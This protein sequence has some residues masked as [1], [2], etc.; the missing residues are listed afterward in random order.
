MNAP[1]GSP[2]VG[3]VVRN[4]DE[5]QYALPIIIRLEKDT[6]TYRQDAL[7]A[8]MTAVALL[9]LARAS[10]Q[11]WD[12]VITLWMND[13]KHRKI[14]RKAR[15]AR[16]E[17]VSE[18]PGVEVT[19]RTATVRVLVPHLLVETPVEVSRLQV[20]GIDLEPRSSAFTVRV[21]IPRPLVGTAAKVARLHVAINPDVPMSTG[22]Q[23]A[24]VGHA[25]H[26][27]SL[28]PEQFSKAFDAQ[29]STL[30]VDIVDWADAPSD[31]SV[32][33]VEDAGYTEVPPGTVT[34][35]AWFSSADE[36]A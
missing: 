35:K 7:V 3:E 30:D 17:A 9:L 6:T 36:V 21:L 33:N 24:Q 15:G 26:Y 5:D 18:L 8:T 31:G 10:N 1:C 32:I 11:E 2:S 29:R 4:Y 14:A 16:W 20:A 19:Y 13:D 12:R 34:V 25:I 22:K 28:Y 27:A 23:M